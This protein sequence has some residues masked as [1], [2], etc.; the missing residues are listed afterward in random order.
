MAD[1][2]YDDEMRGG[3]WKNKDKQPGDKRPNMKGF[4][5]I[6]GVRYELAAWTYTSQKTGEKYQSLKL[7]IPQPKDTGAAPAPTQAQPVQAQP[8][9]AEPVSGHQLPDPDDIPF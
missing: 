2:Q 5:Q 3:L 4:L 8:V 7:S 1:K 6:G 9:Q